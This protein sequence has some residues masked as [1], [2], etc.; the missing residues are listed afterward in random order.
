[1]EKRIQQASLGYY[2]QRKCRQ[3]ANPILLKMTNT[4]SWQK[5]GEP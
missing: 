1:M 5:S 4:Q 2:F 3:F